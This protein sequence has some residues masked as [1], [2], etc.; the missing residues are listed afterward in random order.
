MDTL[1]ELSFNFSWACAISLVSGS[2]WDDSRCKRS[3]RQLHSLKCISFR[4]IKEFRNFLK[5]QKKIYF[6]WNIF[7]YE[8]KNSFFVISFSQDPIVRITSKLW[9]TWSYMDLLWLTFFDWQL[10]WAF[11]WLHL[12]TVSYYI[13]SSVIFW[14]RFYK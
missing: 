7:K 8:F 12:V 4:T 10:F 1:E 5:A 13:N 14:N 11:N 9:K 3:Y 2:S 6:S